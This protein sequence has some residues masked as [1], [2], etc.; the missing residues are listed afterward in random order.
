MDRQFS[1]EVLKCGIVENLYAEMVI[2]SP[3]F[4]MN[5]LIGFPE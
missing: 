5:S 4:G 2:I 1:V 3:I